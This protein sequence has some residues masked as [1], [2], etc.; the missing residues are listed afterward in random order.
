M[1]NEIK[2]QLE[3]GKA[4]YAI[5]VSRFNEFIT[6]KLLGGAVDCL[7]RHGAND[8]QITVVW[9]PGS[10][11]IPLAAKKLAATEQAVEAE[12]AGRKRRALAAQAL[13]RRREIEAEGGA[14][15]FGGTAQTSSVAGIQGDLS[16]A[17]G[18]IAFSQASNAV[19]GQDRSAL[20]AIQRKPIETST[21]T[22]LAGQVA[23]VATSV[24]AQGVSKSIF[25][26]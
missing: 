15:G 24:A 19:I 25:T 22:L 6:S 7:Q 16:Q 2:G 4:N 5:V 13:V 20:S 1:I 26:D 10:V 11:E 8:D 12:S 3:A 14:A 18:D 23:N 9:V 17:Y 21:G